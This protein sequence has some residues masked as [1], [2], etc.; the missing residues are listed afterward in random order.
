MSQYNEGPDFVRHI[1]ALE[2]R[3]AQLERQQIGR[4]V[5]PVLARVR[6]VGHALPHNSVT[7]ISFSG[8]SVDFDTAGAFSASA[9][10]VLT[11]P[12]DGVYVVIGYVT[13]GNN[14]TGDRQVTLGPTGNDQAS[15]IVPAPTN[16]F[17]MTVAKIVQLNQGNTQDL[18]VFQ[19]SGLD[20]G[21]G[22]VCV[23]SFAWLGVGS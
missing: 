15:L 17:A 14:A 10:T 22:S 20:L 8:G 21:S 13:M 9:P 12:R 2:A 16:T 4:F 11:A 1:Q 23:L 7:T 5:D 19:T 3:I 6:I 18:R